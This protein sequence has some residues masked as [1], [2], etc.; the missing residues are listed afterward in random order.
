METKDK[1]KE[2]EKKFEEERRKLNELLENGLE[3]TDQEVLEQ[4]RRMDELLNKMMD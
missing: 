2:L 3:M 1:K 4:G